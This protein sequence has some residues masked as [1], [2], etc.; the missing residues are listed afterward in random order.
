MGLVS[1][2]R[3]YQIVDDKNKNIWFVTD[4]GFSIY[5]PQSKQFRNFTPN[6]NIFYKV[7]PSINSD[8]KGDF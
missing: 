3:V 1:N 8:N 2:L 6:Q 4:R 5:N 7:I